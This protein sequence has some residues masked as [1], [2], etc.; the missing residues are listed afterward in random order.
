MAEELFWT[1]LHRIESQQV[2]FGGSAFGK[3]SPRF[4]RSIYVIDS[5]TIQLVAQCI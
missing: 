4:K 3:L 5:S 2:D 1:M